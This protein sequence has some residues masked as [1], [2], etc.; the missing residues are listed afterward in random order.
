[1]QIR[2]IFTQVA[3]ADAMLCSRPF[4]LR[5]FSYSDQHHRPSDNFSYQAIILQRN[6]GPV[7]SPL[8]PTQQFQADVSHE[9]HKKA[10]IGQISS[11]TLSPPRKIFSNFFEKA[12]WPGWLQFVSGH[13]VFPWLDL[14]AGMYCYLE[15]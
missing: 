8:P 4:D 15:V 9:N 3:R 11:G 10:F 1:M 14:C 13:C 6:L 7:S 12:P 2:K 5:A